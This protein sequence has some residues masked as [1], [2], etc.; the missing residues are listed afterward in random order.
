MTAVTHSSIVAACAVDRT[1]TTTLGRAERSGPPH[2]R[3][4]SPH[5]GGTPYR[6]GPGYGSRARGGAGVCETDGG[7]SATQRRAA[8]YRPQYGQNGPAS[9][10]DWRPHREQVSG[11]GRWAGTAGT[12]SR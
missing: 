3:A 11:F 7:G 5:R 10:E 12:G 6:G 8:R 4:G 1:A 9:G 2:G